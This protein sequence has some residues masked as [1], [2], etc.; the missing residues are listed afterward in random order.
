MCKV[1]EFPVIKE[2]DVMLDIFEKEIKIAEIQEQINY[3]EAVNE[4]YKDTMTF[5]QLRFNKETIKELKAELSI[6]GR[7]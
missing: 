3:I 7:K 5:K 2:F 6:L 1:I 4:T